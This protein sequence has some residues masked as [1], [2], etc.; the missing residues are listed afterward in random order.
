MRFSSPPNDPKSDTEHL[1]LHLAN[2]NKA[3]AS[4]N[5]GEHKEVKVRQLDKIGKTL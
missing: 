3:N 2:K 5:S 1:Y 4:V